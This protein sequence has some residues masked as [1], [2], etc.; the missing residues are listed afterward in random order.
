MS[1]EG[2][3]GMGARFNNLTEGLNPEKIDYGMKRFR[4]SNSSHFFSKI[5]QQ[6][7]ELSQKLYFRQSE[8]SIQSRCSCETVSE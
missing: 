5:G 1:D 6:Y 2:G 4:I 8:T 7:M 3:N